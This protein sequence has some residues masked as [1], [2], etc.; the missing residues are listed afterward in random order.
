MAKKQTPQVT[1]RISYRFVCEHCGNDV[2]WNNASLSGT[3]EQEITQ[4]K[5]PEAQKAAEKGNYF[6][7][8]G[9]AGKCK[10]CGGRQSWE[11]AEAKTW[12]KR[13]PLIGLG[14]A[15]MGGFA[16]WFLFGLMGFVIVAALGMVV[17]FVCGLVMY[18]SVKSSISKTTNRFV[19]EFDWMPKNIDIPQEGAAESLPPVQKEE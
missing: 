7:L 11:L 8:S 17:G 14:L 18:I 2:G 19:P 5:I 6:D 4:K 10:S 9:I 1:H 15:G 13:A 12:M 16:L 3:S